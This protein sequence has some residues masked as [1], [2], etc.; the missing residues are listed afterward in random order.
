MSKP[1]AQTSCFP[2]SA[3]FQIVADGA[4]SV[5]WSL[6]FPEGTREAAGHLFTTLGETRLR[7]IAD[8]KKQRLRQPAGA[9]ACL[10]PPPPI[11]LQF[12]ADAINSK[13]K[14]LLLSASL[15]SFEETVQK[16]I[17]RFES[18]RPYHLSKAYSEAQARVDFITP[19]F[20]ALGWDMENEAGLPHHQREV[21]VERGESEAT[22]RPDYNFRI[23]GQT[24][25]YIEAKAPSEGLDNPH[26]ILQAKG[27]AWNTR[28]VFFV[29]L[30][31][32]EEF[33]FYDASR[34]PDERNPD[35]GLLLKLGCADYLENAEKLW[36]FSCERVAAGSLDALL[37]KIRRA[38][39][40]RKQ[41]DEV[42]LDEMTGWREELAKDIHNQNPTLTAKQLNEVVQRLLDRIVF[43]RIAEDRHVI[44]KRQLA[45][46][47]EEWETHGGK[48]PIFD[49]LNTLFHKINDDFNG[50]IFK[51]HLS[52]EIQIDSEILPR[53]IKRLYP[54]K[55]PYRFDVIGVEL[56][57]SIYERY[58][59]NT[60]RLTPKQVRVEEKPEVRKAG[61]VYY[62]PKYIVDYIVRNT[63]GKIIED[64]SPKQI[65]KIRI[66][67]PACGSGSFLIGAFQYLI[68]YHTQW[69]LEHPEQEIR[70]AHPSLDFMREVRTDPDGSKRL[71]VYRKAKILRN[72]LFG[73]DIDPQ[74]V[75]ITMMSLYL[76]ALEG[77]QSQLPPKQH[78]LPELKYNIMCGNSLIG[79]DIYD[80]GVLFT[81][82]ERDRINAFD[83][84][85]VPHARESRSGEFT[86]P[87]GGIKPP[88]RRT[89]ILG[90]PTS[91]GQMM[92]DGG[93]DCVIGNPPYIRI[94]AM[95]EWAPIE[96]EFYKQHYKAAGSG[97]YDIYVVFIEKGLSLLNGQG[98]LGFIC[99]HKFFNARYGAALRGLL[100]EGRHLGH[101][102]HFGDEQ[103][104]EGATTYTCL[105][106]L[107]RSGSK[108]CL[109]E[110]VAHLESWRGTGEATEGKIP[111]RE[112]TS[113]EWSFKVGAGTDLF[114]KLAQMQV[115]LGD[116]A[117]RIYQGPITSAD[118]VYLF[119]D[120]TQGQ[121]GGTTKAFSSEL[122]EWIEIESRILKPVIRSGSIYRYS[123]QVAALVLFP[124]EVSDCSARLLTAP[125]MKS[126]YPLAREYL[127]RNRRLL[128][129]REKGK[130]RD[131]EWYRFGRT[132]NLGMWEQPK[133][134]VPYMVTDLATY[135]DQADGFYFINV[136]TGGYGI[137]SAD[138]GVSLHY[139]CGLLNSRLLDFYFKGVTTPF[140]GGYFAANKQYIERLPIRPINFFEA[141]DKARHDKM[142]AL[143]DRM[144]EMNKKKH[145]GKLAPSELDRLEREIASTDAEIDELVYELYGVSDEERKVIEGG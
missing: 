29:I 21:I 92:K 46:V 99:P 83:W 80:Q 124:Y 122:G 43:I 138:P 27:Y 19:F 140:H 136:T 38:P 36:E 139:L 68:D 65:E 95:K 132:Q 16:L 125:E 105:V 107:E 123:A 137:T 91:I 41:V 144:L 121:S 141:Q 135:L 42:F 66:L 127:N 59:G 23:G 45:E 1:V 61:G 35:E 131:V 74:A 102:V 49:W 96:V 10:E 53:I 33:R 104:F 4:D 2:R 113:S 103:V 44:E 9:L 60:I 111:A 73:V 40:L 63:V 119:R 126:G 97:N 143:V 82:E 64:K 130:F 47:V 78:L 75:E 117:A 54:P 79:P 5:V 109:V 70:H 12:N 26:H 133:L 6:R 142:A 115:K 69:Y 72:N 85:F 15:A 51:P 106:F 52:E 88:L 100:S 37:P 7:Q 98:K 57:G 56:L 81:D 108:D 55:S 128:E 71:S 116:V 8:V 17:R 24:K 18:D 110:R 93:F 129:N 11:P 90:P 3:A 112:I 118:T 84:N 77:E 145:S 13:P 30:T 32:F 25:F 14:E 101:V 94:Q 50:E 39:H 62:T 22:G 48:F 87:D 67:D 20:K 120:F 114:E 76:K 34:Q 58:L 31:D 134:M 28:S 89:A 86:S